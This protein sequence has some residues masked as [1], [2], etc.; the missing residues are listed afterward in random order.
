MNES[1]S[2]TTGLLEGCA[3]LHRGIRD[4]IRR[5][6]E[7][8]ERTVGHDDAACLELARAMSGLASSV[9][10][11]VAAEQHDVL[12]LLERLDAWGEQRRRHLEL[13]HERELDAVFNVDYYGSHLAMAADA[14]SI[15]RALLQSLRVEEE[16]LRDADAAQSGGGAQEAG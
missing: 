9:R 15:A 6:L 10:R 4:E 16:L 14:A 3:P 12:P 8:A 13:E 1:N 5:V 11:H 2:M 7:L